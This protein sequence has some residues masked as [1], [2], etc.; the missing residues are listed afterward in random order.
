I[1][2]DGSVTWTVSNGDTYSTSG[3]N[4]ISVDKG[5][6]T[7]TI[8]A[9]IKNIAAPSSEDYNLD[10]SID[11]TTVLIEDGG[12]SDSDY[13]E[14]QEPATYDGVQD[15]DSHRN[16]AASFTVH[17]IPNTSTIQAN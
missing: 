11:P 10:F 13:A 3:S 17:P 16:S 5:T 4:V 15:T 6:S 9:V 12:S 2:T 14:G 8:T 1:P 7:I